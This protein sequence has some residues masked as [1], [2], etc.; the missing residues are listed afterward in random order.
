M[1][2]LSAAFSH[3]GAEYC[4]TPDNRGT[5]TAKPGTRTA[6]GAR[7]HSRLMLDREINRIGDET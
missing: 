7:L 5:R 6:L 1:L 3:A 4:A 2:F